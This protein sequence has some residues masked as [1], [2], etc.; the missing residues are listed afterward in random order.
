MSNCCSER[1]S[2]LCIIFSSGSMSDAVRSLENVVTY[3]LKCQ[4]I[5]ALQ[6]QNKWH[7]KLELYDNFTSVKVE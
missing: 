4:E 6:L 3:G 1:S 5:K 7:K 2:T